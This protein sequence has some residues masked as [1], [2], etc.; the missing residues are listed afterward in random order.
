GSVDVSQVIAGIDWVVQHRNDDASYPIRALNLPYGTPGTHPAWSDPLTFAVENAWK[1][2]V[3]VVVAGGNGSN[4]AGQLTNPGY[5][6]A[7]LA[8]GSAATN[9]TPSLPGVALSTFTDTSA[10]RNIDLT[11]PGESIVSLRDP[12]SNIDTSFSAAEVGT[13]QFRGSGTSQPAATS[14]SSTTTSR[15][16][17]S[18]SRR[19]RSRQPTGPSRPSTSPPGRV[20]PGW[21]T[22]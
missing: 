8:V 17:A 20:A 6:P 2:G 13:N 5:D 11:A 10:S 21:G 1:H 22:R 18:S 4:S 15:Y 12:K 9:P 19:V 7:V 14:T 16:R 3:V